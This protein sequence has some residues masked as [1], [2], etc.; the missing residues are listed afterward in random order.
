[1]HCAGW[2]EQFVA[3]RGTMHMAS[4]LKLHFTF[5]DYDKLIDVVNV[6][7]PALSRRIDP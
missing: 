3:W 2:D 1:M 4:Y 7:L 5:Y 6:V